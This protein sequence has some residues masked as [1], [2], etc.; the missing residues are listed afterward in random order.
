MN[1]DPNDVEFIGQA[2]LVL[3]AIEVRVCHEI[4]RKVKGALWMI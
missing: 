3:K 1:I 4:T 2:H